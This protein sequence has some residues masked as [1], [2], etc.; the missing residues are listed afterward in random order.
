M[1][2]RRLSI[3]I[4]TRGERTKALRETLHRDVSIVVSGLR[5]IHTERHQ[6]FGPAGID[7]AMGPIGWHIDHSPTLHRLYCKL[8]FFLY[9]TESLRKIFSHYEI[10]ILWW[11]DICQEFSNNFPFD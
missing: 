2:A 8:A 4:R 7:R 9:T 3:G 1:S 10:T 11:V 5:R 6:G